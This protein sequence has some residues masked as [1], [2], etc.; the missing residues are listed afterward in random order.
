MKRTHSCG[1]LRKSDIK[2]SV[3]LQGWVNSVRSHGGILFIN[4]RDR[5]GLTQTVFDQDDNLLFEEA[6]RL[7]RESVIE[8]HGKVIARKEG[9][10]NPG[11]DTGDIEVEVSRLLVLAESAVLPMDLDEDAE[12]TEETRMNYRYLDLRRPSMQKKLI[13]R[14][15]AAFAAREYFSNRGFLEIETPLLVR[16]TPEG[17]RDYIVP[18]R[19][20][21]GRFY[22][23][24]QSPQLYKQILMVSGFDRYFQLARCL[25]DEDLRAD[26]QPEHTQIDIEMSFPGLEDLWS[27]GEGVAKHVFKKTINVDIKTPFQRIAYKEAMEKYGTDKPDIRFG[28][29]LH[30]MTEIAKESDFGVFKDVIKDGGMVKCVNPKAEFTRKDIDRYTDF[31]QKQ[32]AKGLVWMRVTKDGLEGNVAKFFKADLQKRLIKQTGAEEGSFI[33]A[34]ADSFKNT[35]H[36][37]ARVRLR[38]GEELKLY[39][40]KDFAFC[41]IKDFPLFEWNEDDESWEPA[42]HMF[43]MPFEEHMKYLET[44]PGKVHCTQFDMVLNGVEL[45]SGSIRINRPDV[46]ARVMKVIGL[47]SKEL[48]NKFGFLL[49]AFKYG[50]PPHG[51]FA[52]GFDRLVALMQG[53]LDIRDVIAFPKNKNAQ[54]SMDGSPNELDAHQFKELHIKKDLPAKK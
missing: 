33:F 31:A 7:R 15:K 51:G 48:E 54:C 13:L 8:V 25:R 24:P 26:R 14:H 46:Q 6:S 18:S 47:T 40:P 12:V 17:A 23:L 37:L 32:G 29:L 44:D 49:E 53:T 2:K 30:D 50:A 19:V 35:N 5:Y 36:V 45:A 10:T 42:H 43:C 11:M 3:V 22:A 34:V 1:D 52:I 39:D 41:W 20:N 38:L 4:L 16:S 27:I 28:L 21:P 9:M